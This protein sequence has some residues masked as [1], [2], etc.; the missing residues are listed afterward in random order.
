MTTPIPFEQ[1]LRAELHKTTAARAAKWMLAVTALLAIAGEAVPL[2]FTRDVSQTR[3]SYLTWS[4]LGLSRLLP[5]VLM[6]AMTAEWSQRTALTTFTLEPRRSRVLAAKVLTGLAIAMIAA[7]FAFLIAELTVTAARAAGHH[8]TLSWNW[9]QLAGFALFV[10]LTSAIGIAI[11]A[12]L[13]NTAAAIV[14]YFALAA[15][16]SL[17]MVPALRRAGD[18]VNTGQTFGWMLSGEWSGHV[19]QIA[20]SAA[21]WIVLP[22]TIGAVRTVRRDVP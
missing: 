2:V 19:A 8:V 12:A 5:I 4:A 22:L 3:G 15:A 11:G 9:P 1:L 6:L 7:C 20:T 13:H 10:L 18:W 16:A 17:L 21:I 14:A